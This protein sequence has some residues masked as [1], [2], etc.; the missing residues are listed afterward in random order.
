MC[1][2]GVVSVVGLGGFS[3]ALARL[4]TRRLSIGHVT[5]TASFVTYLVKSCKATS[6][7]S[8]RSQGDACN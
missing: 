4:Q 2:D 3:A 1:G 5:P 6:E 8:E 7:C